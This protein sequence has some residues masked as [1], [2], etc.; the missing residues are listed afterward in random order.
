MIFLLIFQSKFAAA[1]EDGD[2]FWDQISDENP[3]IVVDKKVEGKLYAKARF[4][5]PIARRLRLYPEVK[6]LADYL[7][8]K[9][10]IEF[11][12]ESKIPLLTFLDSNDVVVETH[13][14]SKKNQDEI[15]AILN[16]RG[17]AL[18]SEESKESKKPPVS[19][20]SS[21]QAESPS[22]NLTNT[23]NSTQNDL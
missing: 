5:L 9:S 23:E 11:I 2:D 14:L 13:D 18:I 19:L 16:L 3:E 6:K 12:Y 22:I 8:G 10:S 15:L 21:N 20:G 4:N 17:F 7:T 1:T